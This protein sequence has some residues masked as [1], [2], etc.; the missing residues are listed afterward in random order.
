MDM[1]ISMI[2]NI[3]AAMLAPDTPIY[4]EQWVRRGM[5]T[6]GYFTYIRLR[7]KHIKT[8]KRKADVRLT[9]YQQLWSRGYW[10][11]PIDGIEGVFLH[12]PRTTQ[13]LISEGDAA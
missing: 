5:G 4:L 6:T 1:E 10:N 7:A 8:F 9:V 3:Q 12:D 11:V 2:T 13:S